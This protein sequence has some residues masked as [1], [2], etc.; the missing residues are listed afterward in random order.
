MLKPSNK[1]LHLL[2]QHRGKVLPLTYQNDYLT[3]RIHVEGVIY[4]IIL[5]LCINR[6]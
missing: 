1:H 2:T 3:L 4:N 5:R 6:H